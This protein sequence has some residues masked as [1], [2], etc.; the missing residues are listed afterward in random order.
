MID[1]RTITQQELESLVG[2]S[3]FD[4]S[5]FRLED[6]NIPDS[7]ELLE[8]QLVLQR[9]LDRGIR[10]QLGDITSVQAGPYQSGEIWKAS[11]D[12]LFL[13]LGKVQNGKDLLL[14]LGGDTFDAGSL[15]ITHIDSSDVH[16]VEKLFPK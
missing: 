8:P 12:R 3:L 13:Y 11:Y 5:L 15:H 10:S 1:M 6:A 9:M 16:F 7:H 2:R 4:Y 14:N